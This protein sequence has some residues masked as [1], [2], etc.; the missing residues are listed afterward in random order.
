MRT[1]INPMINDCGNLGL[2]G[3]GSVKKKMYLV[4]SDIETSTQ[5]E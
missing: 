2:W 4:K 3:C 5:S 1:S